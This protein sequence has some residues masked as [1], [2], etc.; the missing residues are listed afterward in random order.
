MDCMCGE[1]IREAD[2]EEAGW[3]WVHD[4]NGSRFCPDGRGLAVRDEAR[5][6]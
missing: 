3:M 5:S 4:A 2:F 6:G 1:S